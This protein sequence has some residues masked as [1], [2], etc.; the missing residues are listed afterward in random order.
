LV[1][2]IHAAHRGSDASSKPITAFVNPGTF[3]S[4]GALGMTASSTAAST[5]SAAPAVRTR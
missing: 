5:T 4:T 2:E 1:P 3:R